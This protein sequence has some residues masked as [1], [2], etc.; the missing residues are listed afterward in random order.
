MDSFLLKLDKGRKIKMN[1]DEENEIEI[2]AE[3]AE[4]LSN[5]KGDED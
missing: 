3:M 5:Q 4:E 2:S 1:I